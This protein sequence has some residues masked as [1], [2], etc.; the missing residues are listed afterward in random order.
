LLG[1]VEKITK[2]DAHVVMYGV[3]NGDGDAEAEDSMDESEG[4]EAAVPEKD[5]ASDQ[6]P[7]Q[8]RDR[9][10][11]IWEMDYRKHACGGDDGAFWAGHQ[12]EQSQQEEV[13]KDELLKEGPENVSPHV[14]AHRYRAV[15]GMKFA[16][17]HGDDELYQGKR[18]GDAD[19]PKG[20][21][22]S[23][24]SEA[25]G[26]AVLSRQDGCAHYPGEGD[27]KQ[28]ALYLERTPDRDHDQSVADGEFEEITVDGPS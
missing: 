5:G 24:D 1:V 22:D 10:E 13:L 15:H 6:T 8:G 28:K 21:V 25:E 16:E 26:F 9:Q 2:T 11:R 27:P 7:D 23:A 18:D 4:I 3:G 17:L 19:E 20:A 12:A 14:A